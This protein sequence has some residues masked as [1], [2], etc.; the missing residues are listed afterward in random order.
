M[1]FSPAPLIDPA[2]ELSRSDRRLILRAAWRRWFRRPIHAALYAAGLIVLMLTFMFLPGLFEAAL[3]GH[4]W[5]LT[6][7]WFGLYLVGLFG[8]L[9]ALR[10]WEFA[11]CVYAELRARGHEVCPGCGY[12][13]TG[14]Q[15][16]SQ[17]TC[18]E[19]GA[20]GEALSDASS[21]ASRRT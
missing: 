4:R 1:V 18:P 15:P 17:R 8:V 10:Q 21:R 3:G 19:C 9:W 12:V 6:L 5:Y 11:P 14:L 13:L 7:I 20:T 16:A 2:L